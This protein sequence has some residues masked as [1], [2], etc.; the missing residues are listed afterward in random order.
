MNRS[1][2][3]GGGTSR[4]SV[5]LTL[6]NER[7][8]RIGL[9]HAHTELP[10]ADAVGVAVSVPVPVAVFVPVVVPVPVSFSAYEIFWKDHLA[11]LKKQLGSRAAAVGAT[12]REPRPGTRVG[13]SPADR[14]F[15]F[16]AR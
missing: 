13:H 11:E 4:V 16:T 12:A 6:K 2:P 8:T 1:G 7:K 5:R 3:R 9:G 15:R 10:D 14:R